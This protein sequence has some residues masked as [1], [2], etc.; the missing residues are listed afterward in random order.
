MLSP[1]HMPGLRSSG[2]CVLAVGCSSAQHPVTSWLPSPM[3]TPSCQILLDT[4]GSLLLTPSGCTCSRPLAQLVAISFAP[5]LLMGSASR[6]GAFLL[7]LP[8]SC[9]FYGD[10]VPG[11]GLQPRHSNRRNFHF[12]LCSP[13][14]SG[15]TSLTPHRTGYGQLVFFLGP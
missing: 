10:A 12:H 1:Q 9:S 15:V 7:L 14:P 13:A 2:F 11:T 5:I 6:R 3:L 8:S 4:S